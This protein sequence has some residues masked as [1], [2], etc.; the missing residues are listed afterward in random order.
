MFGEHTLWSL[1]AAATDGCLK[2]IFSLSVE[3][4]IS[5]FFLFFFGGVAAVVFGLMYTQM[6]ICFAILLSCKQAAEL[7]VNVR[8]TSFY[9]ITC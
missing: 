1:S 9:G 2:F 6:E 3:A 5:F 4:A 8:P 7:K